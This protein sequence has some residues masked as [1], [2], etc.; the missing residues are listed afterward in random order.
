MPR[1]S[2]FFNHARCLVRWN[3]SAL[4]GCF[5][6]YAVLNHHEDYAADMES[7][8]LDKPW[9]FEMHAKAETLLKNLRHDGMRVGL[10]MPRHPVQTDTERFLSRYSGRFAAVID[11][12]EALDFPDDIAALTSA[13]AEWD[14]DPH[15]VMVVASQ[16]VETDFSPLLRAAKKAGCFTCALLEEGGGRPEPKP[17]YRV[18]DASDIAALLR[19]LNEEFS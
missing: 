10:I 16:R 4:R 12:T 9:E 17:M 2:T 1:T 8:R 7:G 18:H 15:R 13:I 19:Q 14:M 5:L 11:S 6:D 3:S